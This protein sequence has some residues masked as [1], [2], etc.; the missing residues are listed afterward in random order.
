MFINKPLF[1]KIVNVKAACLLLP[2]YGLQQ[3][4]N[5]I[6][7]LYNT[8]AVFLCFSLQ[9]M[10]FYYLYK[11]STKH[12]KLLLFFFPFF[13]KQCSYS[14][15]FVLSRKNSTT[16]SPTCASA[17][18]LHHMFRQCPRYIKICDPPYLR[19]HMER[20]VERVRKLRKLL[21]GGSKKF[22]FEIICM[23]AGLRCLIF[24]SQ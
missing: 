18:R 5:H 23:P 4:C 3:C 12:N 10:L 9:I 6:T 2:S 8:H 22:K 13:F 24:L 21:Q 16:G 17:F 11:L 15:Q 14:F 19:A 7:N 1:K 20:A